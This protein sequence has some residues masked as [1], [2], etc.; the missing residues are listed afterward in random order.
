MEAK[1]VKKVLC[2]LCIIVLVASAALVVILKNFKVENNRLFLTSEET[3]VTVELGE[4]KE[5]IDEKLGEPNTDKDG[6]CH[7]ITDDDISYG[8]NVRYD[9]DK[10]ISL[11]CI[12]A[13][14]NFSVQNKFKIGDSINKVRS[15]YHI[16]NEQTQSANVYFKNDNQKLIISDKNNYDYVLHF[17]TRKD[18]DE[19]I[20]ITIAE[21]EFLD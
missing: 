17:L 14:H 10:A 13:N 5:S 9:D 2:A 21:R 3:G 11:S 20:S 8:L 4:S 16:D 1:I 15:L 7:Y 18:S 12:N 19:I 6:V